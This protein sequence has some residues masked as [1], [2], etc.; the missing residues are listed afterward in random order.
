MLTA[1]ELPVVEDPLPSTRDPDEPLDA[2]PLRK[3]TAPEL[4]VVD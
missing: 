3:Y 2:L 1:P 4:P